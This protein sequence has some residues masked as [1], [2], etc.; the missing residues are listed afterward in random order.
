M[1]TRLHGTCVLSISEMP[2]QVPLDKTT[3]RS[4]LLG[5][6]LWTGRQGAPVTPAARWL[7]GAGWGGS[8]PMGPLPSEA[9]GEHSLWSSL[10]P[11]SPGLPVPRVSTY[12]HS[13]GFW[14]DFLFLLLAQSTMANRDV[15]LAG[16]ENTPTKEKQHQGGTFLPR[17]LCPL[18]WQHKSLQTFMHK[19]GLND[20]ITC[21]VLCVPREGAESCLCW[22]LWK[23]HYPSPETWGCHLIPWFTQKTGCNRA[24]VFPEDSL[25]TLLCSISTEKYL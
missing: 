21:G 17:S 24:W 4:F 1:D 8:W 6:R 15:H 22:P 12:P 23:R 14:L 20:H 16:T 13:G 2:L 5:H 3:Q 11:P 7:Q 10:R 18:S 19:V 25:H 9:T